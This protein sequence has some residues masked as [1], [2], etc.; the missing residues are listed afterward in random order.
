MPVPGRTQPVPTFH[1]ARQLQHG[2]NRHSSRQVGQCEAQGEDQ[3]GQRPCLRRA[4]RARHCHVESGPKKHPKEIF[5]GPGGEWRLTTAEKKRILLNNIYGVDIDAQAVETTKPSLLLKVLEGETSETINAQLSFLHERALPD[6]ANNIKCGNSLVGPDFYDS[7]Q[8]GLLDEEGRYRVNVFDWPAEFSHILST[9]TV[10]A[11]S[12]FDAVI[13]N[14]PYIRME[15]F[16]QLKAYLKAGYRCHDER[17]DLYAYFMERGHHLLAP[18]GRFGMI[19]SNKFLRA[20]YGAP[21]RSLLGSAY[22]VV[23]VVDFAGLRVFKGATVRT[24]VILSERTTEAGDGTLYT[25][26]AG[27]EDFAALVGGSKSVADLT[28]ERSF[29]VHLP[30]NGEAWSFLSTGRKALLD[31][32][33]E[34]HLPLADYTDGRIWMGVKSGLSEAFVIDDQT[35]GALLAE[36]PEAGEIIKPFIVGRDVRRYRVDGGSR[37]LLY[38]FHGVDSTRYPSVVDHLRPYREQLERRATKQAWYELQQPQL[39]FATYIDAPKIVFP[40]IATGPRFAMDSGGHFGSN[41]T[42]FIPMEDYLLVGL[43]NSGLA[44]FYFESVC[45]GL[46]ARVRSTCASSVT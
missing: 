44:R 19:V 36:N 6:L 46:E 32:L 22:R 18:R 33:N 45:A 14:P 39:R 17:S 35:R 24:V 40:D 1:R 29:E 25:P 3:H 4:G 26:P 10:Q 41:T 27:S 42:Y 20:K 13:G 5:L 38:M 16:K 43:L 12:G 8:L 34:V 2:A 28:L 15:Q 11:N 21:L 30:R 37:H 9:D 23:E 7:Q 31:R